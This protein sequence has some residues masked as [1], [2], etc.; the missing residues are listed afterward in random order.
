ML[1]PK[2]QLGT[3]KEIKQDKL[4]TYFFQAQDIFDKYKKPII[5]G[6]LAI[7]AIVAASAYSRSVSF[8]KEQEASVEL[9]KGKTAYENAQYQEAT[10]ILGPLTSKFSG[11]QSAGFGTILLA[12]SFLA[13]QQYDEAEQY[14]RTYLDDYDDKMLDLAAYIGLASCYDQK[15][16]YDKAAKA[17]EEAANFDVESFQAPELLLSAARCYQLA[18]DAVNAKRVL[19][20]MI[21][22]YPAGQSISTAK[23]MLAE[24][25]L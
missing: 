19:Q 22:K 24:L 6:F 18:N 20:L 16:E 21:E 1:K 5:Y 7:V 12:K 3:H 10:R 4:V 9:A 15:G 17:Y 8:N 2:K 11:T 14:F 13:Q 25:S 23:L